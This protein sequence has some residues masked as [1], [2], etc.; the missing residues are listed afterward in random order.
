MRR[1][2]HVCSSEIL[3]LSWP[4]HLNVGH[5]GGDNHG[6]EEDLKLPCGGV[7]HGEHGHEV[8]SSAALQIHVNLGSPAIDPWLPSAGVRQ[9]M[10]SFEW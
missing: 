1:G 10:N 9:L 6:M 7:A 4:S 5:W 8:T 3:V 2:G